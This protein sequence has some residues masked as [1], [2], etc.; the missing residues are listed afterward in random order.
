MHIAHNSYHW[1][2]SKWITLKGI[3]QNNGLSGLLLFL[4]KRL[5][6]WIPFIS[7]TYFLHAAMTNGYCFCSLY[8]AQAVLKHR[9]TLFSLK[10]LLLAT[11]GLKRMVLK[12]SLLFCHICLDWETE[13][14]NNQ[15]AFLQCLPCLPEEV[16]FYEPERGK[17]VR[18]KSIITEIGMDVAFYKMLIF[19][20]RTIA[21]L[22]IKQKV[23]S[24][25]SKV[26][27][28]KLATVE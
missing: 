18:S 7:L 24:K 17:T 28:S 20:H 22:V 26:P 1:N 23:H 12:H 13:Q 14:N 8:F 4:R 27:L 10:T 5:H 25:L 6:A 15:N 3:V 19:V 21:C 11:V 2:P 9:E 16:I